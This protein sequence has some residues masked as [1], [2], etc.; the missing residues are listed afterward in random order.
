M[1]LTQRS[2]ASLSHPDSLSIPTGHLPLGNVVTVS[3]LED[4]TS[5][6]DATKRKSSVSDVNSDAE[7]STITS[8]PLLKKQPQLPIHSQP[9]TV[10]LVEDNDINLKVRTEQN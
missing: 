1:F 3:S 5:S 2:K 8:H 4:D 6:S 7:S 9:T 10:L